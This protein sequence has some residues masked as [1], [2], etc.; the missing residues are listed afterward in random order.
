M[1]ASVII[2]TRRRSVFRRLAPTAPSSAGYA[3]LSNCFISQIGEQYAPR[4]PPRAAI[5]LKMLAS[6]LFTDKRSRL[7]LG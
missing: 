3:R 2:Y 6:N 4:L 5:I 7:L 1:R